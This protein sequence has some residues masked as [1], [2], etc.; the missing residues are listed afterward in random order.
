[1]L[2]RVFGITF[3]ERSKVQ[4]IVGGPGKSIQS[5]LDYVTKQVIIFGG[6]GRKVFQDIINLGDKFRT[7]TEDQRKGFI[8]L[9]AQLSSIGV[10]G[11]T[12][13]NNLEKGFGSIGTALDT[14]KK[15]NLRIL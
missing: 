11:T 12:V 15:V 8:Q 4:R 10:T 13:F 3:D 2:N 7:L 9:S 14:T 5:S 1:M 6:H